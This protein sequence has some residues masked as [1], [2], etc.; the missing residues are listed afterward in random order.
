MK[1]NN[2]QLKNDQDSTNSSKSLKFNPGTPENIEFD[3]GLSSSEK[4]DQGAVKVDSI[5]NTINNTKEEVTEF[6]SITM[7]VDTEP[8]NKTTKIETIEN[9][10][11]ETNKESLLEQKEEEE[12]EEKDDESNS[13]EVK[14]SIKIDN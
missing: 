10:I 13:S 12:K 1:I 11:K 2:E 6:P 8:K 5:M 9:L 14:K 7:K 3:Y 4:N